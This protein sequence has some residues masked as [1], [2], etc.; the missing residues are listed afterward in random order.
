MIEDDSGVAIMLLDVVSGDRK[1]VYHSHESMPIDLAW[2]P[3]GKYIV[4]LAGEQL[5][6]QIYLP[7]DLSRHT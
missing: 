1:E 4:F 3:D 5:P 6:A 2:S 7:I